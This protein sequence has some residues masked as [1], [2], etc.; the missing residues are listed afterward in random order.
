MP[1]STKVQLSTLTYVIL[2]V[3]DIA[4]ATEFYKEKL[5]MK[6]KVDSPGWVEIETGTTTLALHGIENPAAKPKEGNPELTFAVENVYDAHESLAK[7]G[8]KFTHEPHEV[9]D[10]GDKVGISAAFNDLDGNNLSIF[11]YIAKDKVKK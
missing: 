4:K 7:S 9:C 5:G 2:Y 8:V 6:I 10:A 11:S 1:T 3:K